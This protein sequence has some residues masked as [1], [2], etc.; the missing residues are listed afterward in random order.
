MTFKSSFLAFGCL[1]SV[2]TLGLAQGPAMKATTPPPAASAT[3]AVVLSDSQIAG[4]VETANTSEIEAGK[5]A[6][7]T[8][9]TKSVKDFA[10]MMVDE[11]TQVNKDLK[12]LAA[13]G[14]FKGTDSEQEKALK[15]SSKDSLSKLKG[16]KAAE[17]D[18]AYAADQ[19][20]MHKTLLDSLDATLIPNAKHD[21]L[22]TMLTK[23]RTSVA[24]HLE[25][26]KAL[27]SSVGGASM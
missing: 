5:Q 20:N 6:E 12:A 1:I 16:L 13:R 9:K 26:A 8:S 19:V 14:K 3:P 24:T 25:K 27:S 4:I 7:K 21:E 17:F 22:K 10:K 11:H 2:S 18:K 23:V 15:A